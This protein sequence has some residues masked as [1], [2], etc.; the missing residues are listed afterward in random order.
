MVLLLT[1][2][3]L[4]ETEAVW[5]DVVLADKLGVDALWSN[6]GETGARNHYS[7]QSYFI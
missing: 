4:W 6:Y 7:H 1:A 2:V 3:N 5:T